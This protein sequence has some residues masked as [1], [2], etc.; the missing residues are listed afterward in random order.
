MIPAC[1][2]CGR[3]APDDPDE[4]IANDWFRVDPDGRSGAI[5]PVWLCDRCRDEPDA[6]IV[7]A[8]HQAQRAAVAA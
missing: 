3:L 7:G 8:L 4:H 5:Q 2:V 1:A 6:V